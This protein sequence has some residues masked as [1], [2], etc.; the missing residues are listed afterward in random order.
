MPRGRER[1][2]WSSSQLR[3]SWLPS[4]TAV[5]APCCAQT[6]GSLC[7]HPDLHIA[8]EAAYP[9]PSRA[10][11]RELEPGDDTGRKDD[12]TKQVWWRAIPAN[13]GPLAR[14]RPFLRRLVQEVAHAHKLLL[15]VG[16]RKPRPLELRVRC[17]QRRRGH[18]RL[19]ERARQGV[20]RRGDARARARRGRGGGW[21]GGRV[22]KVE[23]GRL[24]ACARK[25]G[26]RD[27]RGE[28]VGAAGA[29]P[30]TVGHAAREGRRGARVRGVRA[31]RRR[32]KATGEGV[33]GLAQRRGAAAIAILARGLHVVERTAVV[34]EQ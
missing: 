1:S 28:R 16:E 17:L 11:S 6:L 30:H 7:N 23:V 29:M 12:W 24:E 5:H 21:R 33:R 20:E 2:R 19:R 22:N 34:V 8:P 15:E 10:R 4:S 13:G 27:D 31:E 9:F 32:G 26:R 3:G 14:V 18:V 25:L